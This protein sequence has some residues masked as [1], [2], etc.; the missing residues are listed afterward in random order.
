MTIPTMYIPGAPKLY[1]LDTGLASFLLDINDE[2]TDAVEVKSA[3]T[4]APDFFKGIRFF[5]K[6]FGDIRNRIVIY[7]E[8]S[9]YVRKDCI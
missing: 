5:S 9:S 3:Q 8:N 7:G 6:L 1:F 4:I 2:K